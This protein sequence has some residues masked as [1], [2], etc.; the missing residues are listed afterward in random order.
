MRAIRGAPVRLVVLESAD[1]ELLQHYCVENKA[2]LAPWEPVRDAAY[3]T[4]PAMCRLARERHRQFLDG[5]AV[6]LSALDAEGRMFA[7]C[8][9]TNIVRGAFQACNLGYS[10]AKASEGRG[11][12]TAV[13]KAGIDVMFTDYGLHRIQ[14]N[15]MPSNTRS[16][17]LLE[18]CGFVREGLAKSYLQIAG[19][20]ED[21][22]LTALV[23][24]N[25]G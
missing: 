6:H 3:Y 16:A 23:N 20:W 22:V 5:T 19:R 8:A 21:H 15:Y 18:R 13:V 17:S 12:M 9:F 24:P 2:H 11:L 4:A 10:I 14:A 1:Y 25:H 7:D